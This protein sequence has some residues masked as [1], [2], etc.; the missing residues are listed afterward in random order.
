MKK[1]FLFLILVVANLASGQQWFRTGQNA[2]LMLSGVDFNNTGGP[3]LFN[4]P[5]GIASDG[6]RFLLC[7]RFNNRVLIWKALPTQWDA[8]PDLVLGQENFIT[9]NPGASKRE[10][11]W[12][13]NV[14]AGN[15]GVLAIADTDN[16][17]ILIWKTFP[18]QNA[19]AADLS[20]SLPAITP[21][22]AVLRYGWPWG[23]WTEGTRLAAVATNGAALLFWN[24]LP[25]RDNQPPDYTLSFAQFGTIRNISTD[26]ATYFFVGDH[27]AKVNGD[28][29]GTF[30]WNSFPTPATPSFD[31]FREE[32]IKGVKLPDGKLIAGGLG[33]IYIWNSMPTVAT[34]NPTLS[35]RNN[36]YKNGDGPDVVYAGG[37]LYVNNYNG[38][39]VHVYNS[40]PAQAN[41]LP[42]FALGSSSVNDNT[43]NAI[44]YIQNP[45]VATDGKV[46][47]VT[48]DF[49]A[50]IWIW[51]TLPQKSGLAP[52]VKIPVRSFNLAPWDNALHNGR[53]VVAGKERV[54]V[55]NALP[56]NGEAPSYVLSNKIGSVPL[57][58]LRGVAL[59]ER[60]FY[61]AE[62]NGA[63]AIW[64]G[65][66]RT[67]NEEPFVQL[68]LANTPLNHLH[69]DGTYFCVTAQSSQPAVY[70]YRV[71][72]VVAGGN[73]Q[74]F[75]TVDRNAGLPLNQAAS[76][77]T[78]AG[79]LA[80]ANRGNNSV[81]LWQDVADAGDPNKVVVL[82]QPG[83]NSTAPSIGVNRLF[84]PSAVAA[85][86]NFL[87]VGEGKFSSRLLRYSYGS[88]TGVAA[89]QLAVAGY[90]LAQN[91]PNPFWSGAASRHPA[92]TIRFTLP[93]PEQVTL[94]V[95][96]AL[97]QEVKTLIHARLE[98]GAH[99]VM[100][101]AT[102]LPSG[103][104]FYQLRA[105]AFSQTKVME[106]VK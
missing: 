82:G 36:L 87:W 23:V 53:L 78:F 75:K 28:G 41:Q 99:S 74:P 70:V 89:D 79:S 29:P 34:Q 48:S 62:A 10:L 71:A 46:L 4:H 11:N 57:R 22:G 35:V 95:F 17:R 85:H 44:N 64:N 94:K 7:D 30:F 19:A 12:P 37:R 52:E 27:N 60:F 81:L 38:N 58:D 50:T 102:G 3:L 65:L 9:N 13:G 63:L 6:T 8:Q 100:F 15:N 72:D 51:K 14:S 40:V 49:D 33:S 96:N 103:V 67:G 43:L 55:W 54:A 105:S 69:S 93:Q 39:N 20:I 5:S 101:D 32:W 98:A 97:G 91:Y 47:V 25:T 80:V 73:L 90:Q 21:A 56:L 76:A 59:D 61:L 42:D 106:I 68:M 31:F 2:D 83:L 77:M 86:D 16:D 92:T 26:G 88:T 66:P 18:A 45:V 1:N 24:T 104:Y 84:M